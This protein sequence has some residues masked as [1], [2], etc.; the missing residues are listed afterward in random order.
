MGSAASRNTAALLS[1]KGLG[2]SLESSQDMLHLIFHE[3]RTPL[4][5]IHGYASILL[6]GELGALTPP[7]RQTVDRLKELT[8]YLTTLISNLRQLALLAD[9]PAL[10]PWEPLD[11]G[12]LVRAVCHDLSAEAD[13]KGVRLTLKAPARLAPL[14]AERNGVTQILINLVMNAIKFTPPK[15]TVTVEVRSSSQALRLTVRDTGVG[16]PRAVLPKLFRELY[17]QDHPEV[18]ALGGSG[19]GLV[20][21]KRNV[22]R[23]HGSVSIRS[24]LGRGTIVDVTLPQRLE[25]DVLK[26]ALTQMI[27]RSRRERRSFS[28]LVLKSAGAPYERLERALRDSIR[29]DDRYYP[30][31]QAGLM[32]LVARTSLRG[33][34]TIS[35]RIQQR[36]QRDPELRRHHAVRLQLGMAAY[37]AHGR[38]ASQL[39]KAAQQHLTPLASRAAAG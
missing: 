26:T 28:L 3:L 14:W 12:K 29:S 16:I 9:E 32:A 4:S 30:L 19:L 37:P 24:R 35:E 27:E 5:S 15:G 33:A 20:I 1:L 18:G 7:Q 22:E 34:Q 10:L 36:I 13:R 2:R 25:Q 8:V 38:R 6:T 39:F 31:Q 17:H 23:H 11:I 21:V